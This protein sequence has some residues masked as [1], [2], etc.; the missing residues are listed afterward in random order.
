[1]SAGPTGMAIGR[2]SHHHTATIIATAAAKRPKGSLGNFMHGSLSDPTPSRHPRV[3]RHFK[4]AARPPWTNHPASFH[5]KG[6]WRAA[7]R[8]ADPFD[9]QEIRTKSQLTAR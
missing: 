6:I 2:P 9:G 5:V 1:M 8:I 3:L 7:C 4:H